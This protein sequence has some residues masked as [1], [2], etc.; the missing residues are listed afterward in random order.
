MDAT[1]TSKA[2]VLRAIGTAF[3]VATQLLF[4]ITVYFL[5]FFLHDGE[6]SPSGHWLVIDCVLALQFAVVHSILLLPCS[7]SLLARYL[8]AQFYGSIFAATTCVGLGLMFRYWRASPSI[9]WEASGWGR[10]GVTAGFY[11]SWALLFYSLKQTGFGYQT[12][13]TQWLYWLRRESL[14]RR[15]FVHA[16]I[17]RWM[18]HPAYLSFLGLIWFT[19]RM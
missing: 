5:F 6:N 10:A 1:S 12:G 4:L 3:G 13:W 2:W 9:V 16:G 8:P 15:E 14:P 7:R 17:Y 11:V 19:P 18:R